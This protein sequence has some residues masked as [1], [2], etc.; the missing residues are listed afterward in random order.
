[1]NLVGDGPPRSF[2]RRLELA[3]RQLA[4]G[5]LGGAVESLRGALA[6]DP[7]HPDVHA[8]LAL[9]L[10][11]MK[12]LHAADHEAG[13]ALSLDPLGVL[14]LTASGIVHLSRRHLGAAEERFEQLRQLRPEDPDPL[15][16]L[17]RV[18]KLQN[19]RREQKELLDESLARDPEDVDTL[20]DLADWHLERGDLEEAE[21]LVRQALEIE[22]EDPD[23]LLTMGHLLLRRGEVE[24]AREHA[25]WALRKNPTDRGALHLLAA[26]KSRRNPLLGLWWRYS[27]WMGSLGEGRAIVVLLV[28]Y[29]AYR[30]AVITAQEV[31]EQPGIAAL[32]SLGWL[33]IVAYTW[34]GPAIFYRSLKKELAGVE[35]KE[36]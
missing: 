29:V 23:A 25:V 28:A 20:S 34:F 17:A 21:R 13:I 32:V 10:H 31:L 36:F 12:R 33:G 11:D 30:F 27:T 6:E 35:L 19:R 2:E 1:M 14:P 5:Q 26:V 3:R 7:D 18:R 24:A 4:I 9:T 15:R 22:P 16:L 8:L